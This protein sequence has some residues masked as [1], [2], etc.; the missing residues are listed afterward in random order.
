MLERSPRYK[1]RV[2]VPSLFSSVEV[3]RTFIGFLFLSLGMLGGF[4]ASC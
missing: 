4:C 1:S 3:D 2:F